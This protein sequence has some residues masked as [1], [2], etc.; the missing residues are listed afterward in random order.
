MHWD[1]SSR[2]VGR[3]PTCYHAW[4]S[5]GQINAVVPFSCVPA[6]PHFCLSIM[7]PLSPSFV[8]IPEINFLPMRLEAASHVLMV[9]SRSN[10]SRESKQR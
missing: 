7:V 5:Q 8:Y 4:S 9:S 10:V 3:Q 2:T 1:G 6:G